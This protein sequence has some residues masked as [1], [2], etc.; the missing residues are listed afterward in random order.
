MKLH[1][2]LLSIFLL[3]SFLLFCAAD[4]I[5]KIKKS[6]NLWEARSTLNKEM[7]TIGQSERK[8]TPNLEQ[9]TLFTS[10]MNKYNRTLNKIFHPILHGCAEDQ[11]GIL[12]KSFDTARETCS[13]LLDGEPGKAWERLKKQGGTLSTLKMVAGGIVGQL[14]GQE[15]ERVLFHGN[16]YDVEETGESSGNA[17]L[18]DLQQAERGVKK[19]YPNWDQKT[20]CPSGILGCSR[21]GTYSKNILVAI[22]RFFKNIKEYEETRQHDYFNKDDCTRIFT[23]LRDTKAMICGTNLLNAIANKNGSMANDEQLKDYER[24]IFYLVKLPTKLHDPERAWRRNH[25]EIDD[26]LSFLPPAQRREMYDYMRKLLD[27]SKDPHYGHQ[28]GDSSINLLLSGPT[29]TGKTF[30]GKKLPKLLGFNPIIMKLE[31]LKEGQDRSFNSLADLLEGTQL[32]GLEKKLLHLNDTKDKPLMPCNTICFIDEI[33]EDRNYSICELKDQ[34]DQ[35]KRIYLPSLGIEIPGFLNCIFTT[36]NSELLKDPALISRFMQVRFPPMTPEKKIGILNK[37]V[38][39]KLRQPRYSELR[40]HSV[41]IDR[42]VE[43]LVRFDDNINIRILIDNVDSIIN[44]V[45]TDNFVKRG[46]SWLLP[47]EDRML[48]TRE[49]FDEL[50]TRKFGDLNLDTSDEKSDLSSSSSSSSSSY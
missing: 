43:R 42:L 50:L 6:A 38:E 41:E 17:S 20:M 29:G 24:I 34:F 18:N 11:Q 23:F 32:S 40:K 4:E 12:I 25:A 7:A 46:D 48:N 36:N 44:F 31:E 26:L 37:T 45:E 35:F 9:K 16:F 2:H 28:E 13:F 47:P 10:R 39:K 3:Q 27:R 8:E 30:V 49:T 22:N 14:A 15:V 5:P 1:L 19:R 21:L 33:D